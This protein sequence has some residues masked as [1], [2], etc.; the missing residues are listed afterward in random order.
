MSAYGTSVVR[1]LSKAQ[2][3]AGPVC[4]PSRRR[5]EPKSVRG[6]YYMAMGAG[7]VD[8][9]AQG[10]R[11][12]YMRVQRRLLAMRRD[13]RM[14]YGWITDGSR[15]VYGYTRYDD[16]EDFAS[17]AAGLY[18][19]DYWADAPESVEVWVEKDAMAGKLSPVVV[20]ECGLHLYV[21]RGFSSETYL[22]EAALAMRED[23]RPTTVYLLTDFDASGMNIAETVG[24]KL[25]EMAD[26]V[27]VD[28]ERIAVTPEQIE[29]FG[30]ITQPVT[31]TDSRAR[32]SYAG[33][34]RRQSS[35]TPYPPP[36]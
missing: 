2:A 13:G 35:S 27:D 17:Y 21:S 24:D 6:L 11:S 28:V 9:D 10:K 15:T 32:S 26:G 4:S 5:S 12:N 1:R 19:K 7:L 18:R 36:I 22:Q 31:G 30:L 20:R 29:E 23:G 34:A 16:P 14:P 33:S 8:K 25:V 3:G